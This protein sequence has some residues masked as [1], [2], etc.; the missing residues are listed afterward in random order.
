MNDSKHQKQNK[1]NKI[2]DYIH[3]TRNQK[4]K[5]RNREVKPL[6]PRI[7]KQIHNPDT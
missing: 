5:T 2:Y 7:T 3:R 4:G 1:I 6:K